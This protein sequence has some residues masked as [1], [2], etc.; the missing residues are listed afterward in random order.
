MKLF[1]RARIV[2]LIGM[3][4]ACLLFLLVSNHIAWEALS[5]LRITSPGA[6]FSDP[7]LLDIRLPTLLTIAILSLGLIGTGIF[8]FIRS[9]TR[10]IPIYVGSMIFI[11]MFTILIWAI[12]GDRVDLV[13]LLA[14]TVRLATPIALGAIAGILCERSGIV[15]IAIEG[16][17]LTGACVG[18][19]IALLTGNP[20][21]GVLAAI[22]AGGAIVMLHALL[23]IQFK[24]DQ[25]ISGTVINI[26][27]VG[28][29]GFLRTS[30]ILPLQ[31]AGSVGNPL[32]NLP[33]PLL[34]QIPILGPIFFN[35]Q[36]IA[37]SMLIMVPLMT[38]LLFR[39]PWGLRTRSIG[40]NPRAADTMGIDVIR[41]RYM[42]VLFA[43]FVA[44]LAGAWF[45]LEA[46]FNF[47][48]VMTNGRGF[49][50]LAAMIFGNWTPAGALGGAM[51]FS[52]SDA[53]QIKIQGFDFALPPQF[54]QMLPYIITIIVLTGV[55]GRTRGPAAAGKPYEK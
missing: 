6:K 42:N 24:T 4:F 31:A 32:P 40:E 15:N 51:L 10:I 9:Y 54:I 37:Y 25:T 16:L 22:L 50:A 14:R 44:G 43:G 27:A 52:F 48:D 1:N 19:I 38:V 17:M 28:V 45:S 41:M 33:I 39:T 49:I 34:S 26:L 13:D 8:M 3:L 29:T 2:G 21:L 47:D 12:S 53:L 55:V 36:P 5:T 30:V 11:G 23:S 35:H 46:T 7:S 20:W 18:F